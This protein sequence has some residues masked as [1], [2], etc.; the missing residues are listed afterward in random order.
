MNNKVKT[1]DGGDAIIIDMNG[2]IPDWPIA[3]WVQS[4]TGWYLAQFRSSGRCSDADEYGSDLMLTTYRYRV[5]YKDGNVSPWRETVSAVTI[6]SR[7]TFDMDGNLIDI[8]LLTKEQVDELR[9]TVC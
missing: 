4:G 7:G 9:A 1:R 2:P 3:A 5:E 6:T 8:C